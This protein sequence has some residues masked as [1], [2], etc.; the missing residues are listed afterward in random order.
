MNYYISV[1]K[2]LGV[3]FQCLLFLLLSGIYPLNPAYANELE[4]QPGYV[5]N[6]QNLNDVL[7]SNYEERKIADM[8]TENVKWLI[9]EK[10]LQIRLGKL[11]D[12]G[13]DYGANQ[14]KAA[15]ENNNKGSVT[16][17][18]ETLAV[19]G[20]K[21]GTPFPDIALDEPAA[22]IKLM[23]NYYLS[24]AI[25]QD[26]TNLDDFNFLMI[27]GNS[28]V[29][30]IQS[31]A[32]HYYS[33]MGRLSGGP[34]VL[35]DGSV[36]SKNL[37]FATAPDDVRGI[38]TYTQVYIDDKPD[39]AWAYLRTMRRVRRIASGTSWMES[40]GGTDLL[41]E[42]DGGFATKPSHY[43]SWK[44]VREMTLL[45]PAKQ[46]SPFTKVPSAK[47]LAEQYPYL[48]LAHAPY[49][50]PNPD[51][52]SWVPRK[53]YVIEGIPPDNHYYSKRIVYLD[54]RWLSI[55]MAEMYDKRGELWKMSMH[56]WIPYHEES[57]NSHVIY[58][59]SGVVADYKKNHATAYATAEP[60]WPIFNTPG[61]DE[62][63]VSV[64]ALKSGR[65]ITPK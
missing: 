12:D 50:H 22:G 5:I 2:K 9:R 6:K 43:K 63:M 37:L 24:G 20:W 27:D 18:P 64:D 61:I 11:V 30:R 35:G 16:L 65:G 21:A 3:A 15:Q 17:N 53:V 60:K 47:E 31:W 14:R 8:L 34:Q 40:V 32:L 33:M 38:G 25:K 1:E 52:V 48:D 7:L 23:W 58:C 42:D 56:T 54:A 26:S 4:L 36:L 19:S 13:V 62:N 49:W 39:D 46:K 57:T 10:G 41:G 59:F 44:F 29:E 51:F 45:V 28:G 55:P